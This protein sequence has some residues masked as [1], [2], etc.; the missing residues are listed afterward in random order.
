MATVGRKKR[1]RPAGAGQAV[2]VAPHIRTPRGPDR[3]KRLVRVDPYRRGKPH[4]KAKG[5]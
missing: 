1:R 2:T 3:G 5:A 4:K